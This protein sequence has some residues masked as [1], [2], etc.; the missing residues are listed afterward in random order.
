MRRF[1]DLQQIMEH[2][3]DFFSR[4][5]LAI[6]RTKIPEAIKYIAMDRNGALYGWSHKPRISHI[7]LDW[8]AVE[9]HSDHC[10]LARIDPTGL[11][12]KLCCISIP[13]EWREQL[14]ITP[15]ETMS[16]Q[17]IHEITLASALDAWI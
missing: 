4:A 17:T 2:L 10:Y 11:D 13:T 3:D 12:W 9:H 14:R 6:D 1:T 7:L 8:A 15:V 5:Q 16:I